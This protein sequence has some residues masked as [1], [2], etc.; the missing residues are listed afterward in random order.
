MPVHVTS[1]SRL[2]HIANVNSFGC[3]LTAG[4]VWFVVFWRTKLEILSMERQ[5]CHLP[6]HFSS[7]LPRSW[8]WTFWTVLHYSF[9]KEDHLPVQLMVALKSVYLRKNFSKKKIKLEVET[10]KNHVMHMV[11]QILG[12]EFLCIHKRNC[13]IST[14]FFLLNRLNF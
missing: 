2:A 3:K 10:Y 6:L 14:T 7:P 8:R 12:L 5:Y 13:I 4:T 9:A 11:K 1:L